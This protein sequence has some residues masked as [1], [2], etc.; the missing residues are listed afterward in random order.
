MVLHCAR[1]YS[2]FYKLYKIRFVLLELDLLC[3][4]YGILCK[5]ESGYPHED[6]IDAVLRLHQQVIIS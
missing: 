2:F 6:G 1:R 4:E 3:S 5:S